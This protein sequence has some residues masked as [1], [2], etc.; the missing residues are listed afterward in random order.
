VQ[1]QALQTAAD[2]ARTRWQLS[3]QHDSASLGPF[4]VVLLFWLL[5]IFVSFGLFGPPNGA[6]VTA[7]LVC[8]LATAGAVFLIV[9][10]NE[11]AGG[12]IEVSSAPLRSA[13]SELGK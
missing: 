9:D 13:V 1:A 7:L 3:T 4:L 5:A 12:L 8:A 10:L 11:P 6:V 2:L